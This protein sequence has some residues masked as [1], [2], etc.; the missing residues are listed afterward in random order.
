MV[1]PC[2]AGRAALRIQMS[3]SWGDQC[4][5]GEASLGAPPQSS[6]RRPWNGSCLRAKDWRGGQGWD[7]CSGGP[8]LLWLCLSA[9]ALPWR[10]LSLLTLSLRPLPDR[11]FPT[12]PAQPAFPERGGPEGVARFHLSPFPATANLWLPGGPAL[13]QSVGPPE[14][15]GEWA[16]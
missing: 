14:P 15:L 12:G 2:R 7:P 13:T 9:H 5:G 8:G 10:F 11:C 6:R 4:L 16:V 1:P 3:A